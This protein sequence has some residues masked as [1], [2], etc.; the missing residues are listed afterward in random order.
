[1]SI[2]YRWQPKTDTIT[3]VK[4]SVRLIDEIRLHTGMS[5]DEMAKDLREK[6][7]ILQWM[8]DNNI[9]TVNTV[10]KVVADYYHDRERVLGIIKKNRG[11]EEILGKLMSELKTQQ[12]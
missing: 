2:L 9:K 11:A 4:D 5:D 8:L 7:M 12:V 1:M 6:E 3:K 10:G